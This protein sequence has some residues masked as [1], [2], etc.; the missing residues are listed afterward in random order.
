M[1]LLEH[2][3]CGPIITPTL[4]TQS[5]VHKYCSPIFHE[6]TRI[7]SIDGEQ[8]LLLY[9]DIVFARSRHIHVASHHILSARL[10]G[11]SIFVLFGATL[12]LSYL[13]VMATFHPLR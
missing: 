2:C 10:H 11:I 8:G 4:L 7:F 6:E 9:G 12:S 5:C 3:D 1:D 13:A